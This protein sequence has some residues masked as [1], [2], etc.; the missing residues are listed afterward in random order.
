VRSWLI[1]LGGLIVWAVHFF[2]VY[3]VG[4]IAPR[5]AL[6]VAL[7]LA[8]IAADLW[9]IVLLRR[10]PATGQY[11]AWRRSVGLGGAMLSLLAVIWQSF[12][13]LSG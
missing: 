9:L 3:A 11:P 6:V 4:E 13:A 12:P 5:P 2:T 10:M 1:L 8:C 7:T